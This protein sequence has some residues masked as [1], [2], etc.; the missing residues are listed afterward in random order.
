[1]FLDVEFSYTNFFEFSLYFKNCLSQV[2]VSMDIQ[3]AMYNVDAKS[4]RPNY[5]TSGKNYLF[6]IYFALIAI[7]LSL[8][9]AWII[10]LDN[11]SSSPR[12]VFRIHYVMLVVLFARLLSF[13]LE[14]VWFFL[15]YGQQGICFGLGRF[16]PEVEHQIPRTNDDEEIASAE[17]L[18]DPQVL[19]SEL[20][21][22][23]VTEQFL[24]SEF[25]SYIAFV[26][27]FFEHSRLNYYRTSLHQKVKEAIKEEA[28][29]QEHSTDTAGEEAL[30]KENSQIDEQVFEGLT[31]DGA[32]KE[33]EEDILGEKNVFEDQSAVYI[34]ETTA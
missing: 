10:A 13:A 32:N 34:G 30:L 19:S 24:L 29:L 3:S 26:A 25:L 31:V 15:P 2:Q 17:A 22:Q 33:I 23:S 6:A 16:W 27:P 20:H 1:M 9:A 11:R 8:S 21:E 14:L 18:K 28:T 4:G 5:L 7:Y 12:R